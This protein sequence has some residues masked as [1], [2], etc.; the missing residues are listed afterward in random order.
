M[1]RLERAPQATGGRSRTKVP[2]LAAGPSRPRKPARSQPTHSHAL[3]AQRTRGCGCESATEGLREPHLAPSEFASGGGLSRRSTPA[4]R[5]SGCHSHGAWSTAPR[6]RR[7]QDSAVAR[8]RGETQQPSVARSRRPRPQRRRLR[9]PLPPQLRVSA[10]VS[11]PLYERARCFQWS[12]QPLLSRPP[13][14]SSR[15]PPLAPLRQRR[16]C[17]SC[18]PA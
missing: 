8:A 3:H 18:A 11:A 14:L 1:T 9:F 15:S 4:A 13:P 7:R 5:K 12:L 6:V 2:H 16:T 17:C 10:R